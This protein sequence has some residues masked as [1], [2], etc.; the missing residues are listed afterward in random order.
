VAATIRDVAKAAGVSPSTVS[1]ALSSPGLVNAATRQ[2][3]VA[4]ASRLGYRPNRAARGLITGRT[5]NLGLIVPDVANPFFSSVVKGG[6]ARAR[7]S[8]YALF[9]ANTDEEVGAEAELVRAL[10]KQVDG[11]VLCSPRMADDDLVAVEGDATVV[12]MH[13]RVL[14]QPSITVDNAGGMRQA[15]A[16]VSALG[17]RKVAYVGGPL[18]SWSHGERLRGLREAVSDTGVELV[19]LGS[20]PPQFEGGVA[21]GDLV[22]ASGATAVIAYNDVVAIGLL[23][24]LSARGISVPDQISVIGCDDIPMSAMTH[25]ALT[26][27]AIPKEQSGRA[28]VSL[29]LSLL[30]NDEATT[31]RQ[32]ELPTQLIVRGT[33]GVAPRP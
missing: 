29:L 14:R 8:D 33:T 24:R 28:A 20:F 6:Q 3:V 22:L 31:S 13:R 27:I 9:I 16:H 26:T 5:G 23:S 19:E 30:E 1:R 18:T 32:R 7:E 25:P 4:A 11:I 21:A 12:L 2:R 15:L 17:H 10:S